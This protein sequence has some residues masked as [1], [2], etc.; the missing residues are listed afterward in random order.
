MAVAFAHYARFLDRSGNYIP[1]RSYQNFFVGEART[2]E[3]VQYFFG[4]YGISGLSSS[5]NGDGGQA[6]LI[7]TA[8]EITVQL[9]SEAIL[10]RW[11]LEVK[12]VSIV[13]A[14]SA[15]FT[16]SA[17]IAS[18]IWACT[19]G[20]SDIGQAQVVITLSSPL[21]AARQEIPGRVLTRSM[22]GAIPPTGQIVIS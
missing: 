4:P 19:G 13:V 15:P 8:N 6:S 7:S 2:F 18:E 20:S 16:E 14:E 1:G 12:T 10:S 17:T 21:N 11:L 9:F 3:S 22:V 5:R